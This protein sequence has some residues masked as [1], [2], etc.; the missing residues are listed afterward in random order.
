MK[1][2]L[3]NGEELD[4]ILV[5][6]YEKYVRGASRDTLDIFMN[7]EIDTNYVLSLCIPQNLSLLRLV[8][9]EGN[10]SIHEGYSL[11]V[12]CG[13]EEFEV[14]KQ[15]SIQDGIYENRLKL[16]LAQK[17]YT[18]MQTDKLIQERKD[19]EDKTHTQKVEVLEENVQQLNTANMQLQNSNL[20]SQLALT[21]IIERQEKE[22]L[23]LQLALVESIERQE[24][25][26]LEVQLALAEITELYAQIFDSNN[27]VVNNTTQGII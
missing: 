21:E 20:T 10:T 2:I 25:D 27:S 11:F 19:F 13:I 26:K 4:V 18:E 22:K 7:T 6:A 8:S 24:Q 17:T 5:N 9:D 14:E 1:L 12:S 23:A 16:R 3:N 15:T